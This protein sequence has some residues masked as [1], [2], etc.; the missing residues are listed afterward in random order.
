MVCNVEKNDSIAALS[1]AD[2]TRPIEPVRPAMRST[3]RNARERNWAVRV[4]NNGALESAAGDRGPQRGDGEV[5]G[6]AIGQGVAGDPVGEDVLDRAAVKLA[7]E[8]EVVR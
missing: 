4:D 5:G 7:L 2:A 6:H 8:R 1:P 3:R